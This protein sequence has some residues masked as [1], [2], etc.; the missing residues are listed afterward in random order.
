MEKSTSVLSVWLL[1]STCC[2]I[3]LLNMENIPPYLILS[4]KSGKYKVKCTETWTLDK[5]DS[6]SPYPTTSDVI[7]FKEYI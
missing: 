2:D 5:H 4:A 6:V 1:F 7:D 3:E